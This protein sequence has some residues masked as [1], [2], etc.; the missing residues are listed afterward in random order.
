LVRAGIFLTDRSLT[1]AQ[2]ANAIA[3]TI[4]H[5]TL[6]HQ[7]GVTYDNQFDFVHYNRDLQFAKQYPEL[8]QYFGTV[9]DSHIVNDP[10]Y[11]DRLFNGPLPIH[12]NDLKKAQEEL[13]PH[14]I[15]PPDNQ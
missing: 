10:E 7:F 14:H 6:A 9:A 4:D 13:R 5:E 15:D 2:K 1:N 3:N 12:P 8:R 11:R